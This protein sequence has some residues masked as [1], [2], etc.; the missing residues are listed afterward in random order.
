MQTESLNIQ[1][2]EQARGDGRPTHKT[3]DAENKQ[4]LKLK[5]KKGKNIKTVAVL[6]KS[7]AAVADQLLQDRGG[8]LN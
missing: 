8:C 4:K 2:W 6:Q 5:K 1:Q 7:Q 3:E